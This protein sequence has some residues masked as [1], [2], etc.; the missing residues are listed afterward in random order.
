VGAEDGQFRKLTDFR[1]P[2]NTFV[3]MDEHPDSLNDGLFANGRDTDGW[4]D[5]PASYHNGAA[6]FSFA[7]GHSEIHRWQYRSTKQPSKPHV[8]VFPFPIPPGERGDKQWL[9]DRMFQD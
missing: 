7:D 5:V 2:A 9:I 3:L 1:H 8:L 4:V 6:G